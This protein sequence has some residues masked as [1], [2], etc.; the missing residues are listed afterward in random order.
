MSFFRSSIL[1]RPKRFSIPAFS[2]LQARSLSFSPFQLASSPIPPP[3]R[4]HSENEAEIRNKLFDRLEAEGCDVEDTSG[5]C[6]TFYAIR[7]TSPAFVGLSKVK[8]HRLVNTILKEEI[9]GIH[10]LTLSTG[11][12]GANV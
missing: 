4:P 5:G 8:Q 2:P 1:L 10:G 6:G 3:Y 9:K 11:P 12:P 7:I